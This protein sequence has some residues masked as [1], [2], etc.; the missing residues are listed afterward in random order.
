MRK[1]KQKIIKETSDKL[2]A[3]LSEKA[4]EVPIAESGIV[5]LGLDEWPP[6]PGCQSGTKRSDCWP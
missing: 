1:R 2:I 5:A 4:A 3:K 6:H